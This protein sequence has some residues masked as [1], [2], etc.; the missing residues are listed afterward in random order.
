MQTLAEEGEAFGKE[1][2]SGQGRFSKCCV[3]LGKK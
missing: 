3:I 1:A 2:M